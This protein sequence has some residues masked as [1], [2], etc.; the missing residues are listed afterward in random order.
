MNFLTI[1]LPR[2]H[3][4]GPRFYPFPTQ[5]LSLVLVQVLCLLSM[6]AV[7]KIFSLIASLLIEKIH[8]SLQKNSNVTNARPN[9]CDLTA[10]T[11]PSVKTIV[12]ARPVTHCSTNVLPTLAVNRGQRVISTECRFDRA[13]TTSAIKMED[14]LL[15]DA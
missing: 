6:S 12:V 9:A 13:E 7:L 4:Q 14:H 1:S 8:P 5:T 10:K 15:A 2:R 11:S 3:C